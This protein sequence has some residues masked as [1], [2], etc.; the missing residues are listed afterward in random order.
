MKVKTSLRSSTS[1]C[2]VICDDIGVKPTRSANSTLALSWVCAMV[3]RECLKVSAMGAGKMFSSSESDYLLSG[4]VPHCGVAHKHEC[5]RRHADD[6]HGGEPHDGPVRQRR[7]VANN[8]VER[9][10]NHDDTDEGDEPSPCL[11]IAGEHQRA[12]RAC[13]GP[14]HHAA[15]SDD[16]TQ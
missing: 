5:H 1:L 7:L 3:C 6:V 14:Q 16:A 2:A 11:A 9:Q 4:P 12:Q 10:G 8:R 13:H 15:R